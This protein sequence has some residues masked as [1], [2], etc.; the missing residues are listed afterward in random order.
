MPK[1]LILVLFILLMS[2]CSLQKLAVKSTTGVLNNSIDAIYSE[3]DLE[4]AEQAIA[5]NLKLL[6]GF[7]LSDP[8]NKNLL[9]LL[10]QGYASFS[11]GFVEDYQPGRA[12]VFYLRSVD[13]GKKL[14]LKEGV[15]KKEIPD[16][17]EDWETALAKVNKKQVPA[18]FWTAFAWGSWINL[19][20]DNPAALIDLSKVQAM[21]NRVVELD[22]G[23]FFGTAHLFFG[24]IAGSLPPMLGG[25]PELAKKHFD[26]CLELSDQK[27]MLAYV[28]MAEFYA[29]PLLEEEL[30]DKFLKEVLQAPKDIL[31]GYEL[32]T[33][34]AKRKAN[35]LI[36]KKEDLF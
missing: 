15:F 20:K 1:Y 34:I 25:D 11:L 31:P 13:Y 6:E 12:K 8:G 16:K 10:T 5:A 29:R 9:L 27:L 18:V 14:L 23:F 32:M 7:Y 3:T 19:S 33:A 4:L 36:K 21:M 28:Y 26:K 2:G 24:A 22:E 35:L 17:L 30:F